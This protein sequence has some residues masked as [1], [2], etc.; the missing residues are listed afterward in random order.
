MWPSTLKS[1]TSYNDFYN[2]FKYPGKSALNIYLT[3]IYL[4]YEVTLFDG[5]ILRLYEHTHAFVSDCQ[6]ETI[7]LL[8]IM[9]YRPWHCQQYY[10]SIIMKPESWDIN[11][12][13]YSRIIFLVLNWFES[14]ICQE[15]NLLH[16]TWKEQMISSKS[17]LQ[18]ILYTY[19][20]VQYSIVKYFKDILC[21]VFNII[22]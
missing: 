5:I 15:F 1:L 11:N 13:V 8:K 12:H 2:V 17:L 20:K 21:W 10:A 4:T 16:T 7:Q 18:W 22:Y 14:Y 19:S 6:W 3:I 9:T